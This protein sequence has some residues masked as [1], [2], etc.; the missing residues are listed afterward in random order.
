MREDGTDIRIR[1]FQESVFLI[2]RFERG[3][4]LIAKKTCAWISYIGVRPLIAKFPSAP[5]LDY[6]VF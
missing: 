6:T 1:Y 5:H 4:G 3:T 2:V